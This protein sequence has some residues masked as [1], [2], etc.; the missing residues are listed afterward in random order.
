MREMGVLTEKSTF[1][2]HLHT[3]TMHQNFLGSQNR[4]MLSLLSDYIQGNIVEKDFQILKKN[5]I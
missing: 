4:L 1:W 2:F 5:L 3:K